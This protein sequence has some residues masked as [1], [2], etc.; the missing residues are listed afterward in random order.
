MAL[1]RLVCWKEDLARER[2]H[3]LEAAGFCVDTSPWQPGRLIS[4]LRKNLPAVVLIDLDRLP[5]HG[6]EVA[7]ALR[8]SKTTR[9]IPIVLAG[10]A[11]EK[12]DRIRSEL[13]DAF[14][15][16]WASVSSVL[17]KALQ[18]APVNPVQP[19]PHMQRYA[20]SSLP[21]KLGLVPSMKIA[22]LAAPENWEEVLGELPAGVQVEERI[23]RQTQMAIWFVR[24]RHEL[25]TDVEYT[26][27]RLPTGCSFWI[28]HPKKTGRY[29]TDFNQND[30][31]EAGLRS[32]LV[33][34]KVCAVNDD[35]SGLKFARRKK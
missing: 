9:L 33:D 16:D 26:S 34:Y 6:R 25:E 13:P 23:T 29:K 24:S 17:R 19:T 3:A 31:R 5:S 11:P 18:H 27:A 22:L 14:F 20:A 35:W 4:E 7:V 32:A 12:V 21:K 2:A 1:V 30:V 15:T 10:G 8:V 28:V